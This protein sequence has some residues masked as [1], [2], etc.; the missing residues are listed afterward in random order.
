MVGNV[1]KV[2]YDGPEAAGY[3]Q[4]G[5]PYSRYRR[6]SAV[7]FGSGSNRF[8]VVDNWARRPSGFPL[9]D[10]A[11][12]AVDSED[13][14]FAFTRSDRRVQVY[15]REGHFLD[16]WGDRREHT[17]PHGITIDADDNVWLA[18]TGDHTLKKF[19]R[20]GR[21]L[22]MLGRRHQ[23][24]ERM[25][26]RPFNSPTRLAV[27]SNGDL[28]VSDGYGNSKIHVFT[29][30][31]DFQYSFGEPGAGPGQLNTPHSIVIDETDRI[32]VCDRM[33]SRI[34]IFNAEGEYLTEWNGLHHPDDLVIAPDGTVYV[35]ELQHRISI[36]S[37]TGTRLA[38]WGDEGCDCEPGPVATKRCSGESLDAGMVIGPHAIA[39]DSEGS[40]YVGDLADSYRG[41][42]RGSR[43]LQKF[44]PVS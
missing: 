8:E 9:G 6:R 11:G 35:A 41:V 32:W 33:N 27:A 39:L 29:A 17:T 44:L 28:F 5:E 34:Q 38:G 14:V 1:P 37:P 40:L 36:W 24:A 2:L 30:D 22:L 4:L 31:G 23:N 16:W 19:T 3:G 13:N 26:G 15:D 20:E 42:D 18:D 25:S 43:S 21:P 7:R 12:I 10:V